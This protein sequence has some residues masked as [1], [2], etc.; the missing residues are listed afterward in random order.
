[1]LHAAVLASRTGDR[2]ARVTYRAPLPEDMAH[3]RGWRRAAPG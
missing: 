2:G 1:M 3:G